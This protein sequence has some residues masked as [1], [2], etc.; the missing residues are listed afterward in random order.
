[1]RSLDAI[2]Q[3]LAVLQEYD[4]DGPPFRLRW[5]LYS[6]ERIRPTLYK[7]YFQRFREVFF[8]DFHNSVSLDLAGL[9]ATPDAG[10]HPFN[11]VYDRLK[12]YRMITSCKCTPDKSFLPPVLFGIWN[13]NRSLDPERQELALRQIE[14]YSDQLRHKN[15]YQVRRSRRL[16]TIR[17]NISP[18]SRARTGYTGVCWRARIKR[19]GSQPGLAISLRISG[20]FSLGQAKSTRLLPKPAGTTCK[21]P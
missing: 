12:A 6:G 15:P 3:Q 21:T 8:D 1:L 11:T 18:R 10:A 16:W 19:P 20:R 2:R 9:P 17:A 14:F 13:A 5:G 7:L 4:E